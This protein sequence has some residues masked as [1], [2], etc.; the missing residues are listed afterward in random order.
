MFEAEGVGEGET[1]MDGEIVE[2]GVFD[3]ERL[4]PND[5]LGDGETDGDGGTHAHSVT[6]PAHPRFWYAA[7]GPTR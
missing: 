5:E 6:L 1:D 7:G 3:G 2:A 4:A